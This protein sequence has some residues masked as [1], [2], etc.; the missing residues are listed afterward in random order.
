MTHPIS[1]PS[2]RRLPLYL[3]LLEQWRAAGRTQVSCTHFADALG[4]D[5]TQVRKDL[6]A[7]GASGRPRVG[8]DLKQLRDTLARFLGWDNPG[9]AFLVG[10]GPLGRALLAYEGFA[11]RGLTIVAVFDRA[12][13]AQERIGDKPVLPLSKLPDLVRRMHVRI[14][15]L[16]VPAAEAE[17]VARTM[18]EAGI[19]GIWNF[20]PVRLDLGPRIVV[21]HIDL[22]QSLAVLRH[23]LA[24][25]EET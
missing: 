25:L 4:L 14:G 5:P 10:S 2:L 17:A 19:R 18:A 13:A 20:A 15:I 3:R 12:P 23:R 22:A 6:A 21:E 9:E 8:Y 1:M 11:A 24:A 7:A 16:A